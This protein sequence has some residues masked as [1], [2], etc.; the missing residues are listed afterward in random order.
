MH[1]LNLLQ[2]CLKYL[3]YVEYVIKWSLSTVKNKY[4]KK[5]FIVPLDNNTSKTACYKFRSQIIAYSTLTVEITGLNFCPDVPFKGYSRFLLK[6][7]YC[8]YSMH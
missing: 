7:M 2:F 4:K 6:T 1:C 8:T 3:T 5:Y